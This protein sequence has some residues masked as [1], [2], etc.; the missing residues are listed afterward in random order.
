MTA[1][2]RSPD[3]SGIQ[4]VDGDAVGCPALGCLD[5]EEDVGCLGLG[6]GRPGL[7][8]LV[9]EVG[10]VEADGAVDVADGAEYD[11]AGL[12]GRGKRVVQ[13][14][15]KGE[16]AK[17]VRRELQLPAFGGT[18]LGGGHDAG[19]GDEDVQRS[20][21]RCGELPDRCEV[22][23]V[24]LFGSCE[25]VAGSC[26]DVPC[27]DGSPL[28]VANGDRHLGSGGCEGTGRFQSQSTAASCHDRA[29]PGKVHSGDDVGCR[30]LCIE[31]CGDGLLH[32]G[33]LVREVAA[34]ISLG[35]AQLQFEP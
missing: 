13:A 32:L 2:T 9:S 3:A 14:D 20:P 28:E 16:V 15:G 18:A 19:V 35:R 10:V 29:L 22:G 21:P 8:G 25:V 1:Q 12:A 11:D 6:V 5:R 34:G 17:V 33:V 23:Q 26:R 4:G 7:V 24:Q 31:G 30:R 27:H